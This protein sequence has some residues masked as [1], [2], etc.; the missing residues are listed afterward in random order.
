[1]I[2]FEFVSGK[3]ILHTGDF[4]YHNTILK[5]LNI[6]APDTTCDLSDVDLLFLTDYESDDSNHDTELKLVD[7][8]ATLIDANVI[9]DIVLMDTTFSLIKGVFPTQDVVI[10]QVI[11]DVSNVIYFLFSI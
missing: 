7:K 5:S 9:F 10:A 2:I 1:M 3:R 6:Q 11:E 8:T 4:R